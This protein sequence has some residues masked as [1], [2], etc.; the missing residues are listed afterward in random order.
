[1]ARASQAAAST[2]RLTR[3]SVR[4]SQGTKEIEVAGIEATEAP[5]QRVRSRGRPKPAKPSQQ[6]KT[7]NGAAKKRASLSVPQEEP[8]EELEA[9]EEQK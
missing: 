8:E 3:S 1:M 9:E 6:Q 2:Q 7:S 4:K 5:T